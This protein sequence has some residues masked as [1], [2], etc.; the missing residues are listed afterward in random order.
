MIIDNRL[1]IF[2]AVAECGSFTAA[3]H[4]LRMSQPAVSQCI[5]QLEAE[6]GGPLFERAKASVLLTERGRIFHAHAFRI[7]ALYDSLAAELSGTSAPSDRVRLELGDGRTAEVSV[8][9]GKLQIDIQ[10]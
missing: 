5:A 8:V 2:E 1:K 10:K 4:S 6:S 7:L 3:A 9:S